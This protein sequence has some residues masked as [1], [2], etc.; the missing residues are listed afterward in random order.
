MD[1]ALNYA[2]ACAVGEPVSERQFP[3]VFVDNSDNERLRSVG[4][5]IAR[6]D[7]LAVWIGTGKAGETVE[8]YT[9]LNGTPLSEIARIDITEFMHVTHVDAYDADNRLWCNHSRAW[10]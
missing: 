9:Q 5:L 8:V 4:Y 7:Q 10:V 3:I 6:N 1:E 2:R